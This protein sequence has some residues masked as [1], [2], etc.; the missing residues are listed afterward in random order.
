MDWREGT[1]EPTKERRMKYLEHI[2]TNE[3]LLHQGLTLTEDVNRSKACYLGYMVRKLIPAY[4]GAIQTD[5]RDHYANKRIDTAGMLMSLLF[6][7][8]YRTF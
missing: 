4:T 5:D 2:I 6:R 3:M 8:I 7:Q 1:K